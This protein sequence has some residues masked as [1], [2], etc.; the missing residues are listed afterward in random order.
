M[1]FDATFWPLLPTTVWQP[2]ALVAAA[3]IVATLI[4]GRQQHKK[5]K[6]MLYIAGLSTIYVASVFIDWRSSSLFVAQ[7]YSTILLASVLLVIGLHLII[8]QLQDTNQKHTSLTSLNH[9][10]ARI[11]RA[12][13]P[14]YSYGII[15]A[16]VGLL[17][18][19]HYSMQIYSST[20]LLRSSFS[21]LHV[22]EI[23]THVLLSLS[24]SLIIFAT[25][26][27]LARYLAKHPRRDGRQLYTLYAG[28]G[29]VMIASIAVALASFVVRL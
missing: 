6:A 1:I 26:Y 11:Y 25:G 23:V 15:G 24:I 21:S 28:V 7:L 10:V 12:K 4:G 2:L 13:H 14:T 18:P 17:E 20:M 29:L 16:L 22:I 9:A 3:L 8:K 5:Q 19:T 27:L